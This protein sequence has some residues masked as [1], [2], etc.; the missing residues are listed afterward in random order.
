MNQVPLIDIFH[1]SAM[2]ITVGCFL[3]I[4]AKRVIELS[5]KSDIEKP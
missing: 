3:F 5:S 4:S 1:L 2:A